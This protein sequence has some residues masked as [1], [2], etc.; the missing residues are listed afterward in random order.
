MTCQQ[1]SGGR[2]IVGL[3]DVTS[4]EKIIKIKSLLREDLEIDHVKVEIANDDET[5]SRLLS[6]TMVIQASCPA[7]Q[8]IFLYQMKVGK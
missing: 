2:V 5:T 1:M 8:N 4:P 7:L 6:H 3:R